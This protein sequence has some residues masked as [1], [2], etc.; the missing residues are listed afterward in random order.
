MLWKQA[1]AARFSTDHQNFNLLFRLRQP[2][3]NCGNFIE[4]L[5]PPLYLPA[6]FCVLH[7]FIS[8]EGEFRL[9][10]SKILKNDHVVRTV[11][12][13]MFYSIVRRLNLVSLRV[14]KV[15]G[16]DDLLVQNNLVVFPTIPELLPIR[17]SHAAEKFSSYAKI[18]LAKRRSKTLRPPP[19]HHVF[20]VCPR[21]PNQCAWGI[22]NSSDNHPLCLVNR[23]FCHLRPP[24]FSFD[25]QPHPTCRNSLP[26]IGDS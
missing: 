6:V 18:H 14:G 7:G 24:L 26:R 23:V 19:L 12:G 11:Y 25:L 5:T 16:G 22:K 15:H 2:R 13:L 10:V 20:R 8:N 4:Y 17:R 9:A 1:C 3:N 21:L